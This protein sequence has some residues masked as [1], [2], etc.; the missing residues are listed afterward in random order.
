[1]VANSAPATPQDQDNLRAS[2]PVP[3]IIVDE[4][5]DGHTKKGFFSTLRSKLTHK[6]EN[7]YKRRASV[8]GEGA[9][10]AL[11][12]IKLPHDMKPG[13]DKLRVLKSSPTGDQLSRKSVEEVEADIERVLVANK[14]PFLKKGHKFKCKDFLLYEK[15]KIDIEVCR[16]DKDEEVKAIKFKRSSGSV[17]DYKDAISRLTRDLKL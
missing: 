10:A 4:E 8:G 6:E 17:W 11:G 14:V 5:G 2:A 9:L 12:E 16:L 7:D 1:L 13:K 15:L 3:A